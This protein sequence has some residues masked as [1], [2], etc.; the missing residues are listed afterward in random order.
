MVG[1]TCTVW[2]A[3]FTNCWQESRLTPGQARWPSWLGG[4]PNPP[5]RG[6]AALPGGPPHPPPGVPR[7]RPGVS[8]PV[9]QA[10]AQALAVDPADR[11]YS[12][13]AFA[14]ALAV[15]ETG[16]SKPR[17]V[18]VLPFLNLSTDPE[19]EFFA[20][21]ITEDVIAHLSKI[22]SLKVIS[23][24]S[25]MGFKNREQSL[26]EIG[27]TL[28]VST[29]LEGSVRR[30]GDRVR[31]VAQLV[32]ATADRHLWGETYDRQLTDIFA[33]QSDVA[34]QIASA[35]KA[36]LSRDEHTRLK[37]EPTTNVHAYQ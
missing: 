4:L 35:L 14:E 32:D 16:Q 20:D 34:L 30:A 26:K 11:F 21:G 19:N 36:E 22:R 10:I 37:R 25:V 1:A 13:R 15:P 8:P 29:L 17:S 9:E 2:V 12:A 27:A 23:R 24:T 6:A 18:A 31:I 7:V 28:E 33:I 5:P 3:C